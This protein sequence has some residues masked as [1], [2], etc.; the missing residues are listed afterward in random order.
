MEWLDKGAYTYEAEHPPLAP[1]A[2][3]LGPY[4][5]DSAPRFT[6]LFD[7]GNAS[8]IRLP[9]LANLTAGPSSAICHFLLLACSVIFLW[10][11]AGIP[12]AL[13]FGQSCCS[14]A[15]PCFSVT[16]LWQPRYGPVRPHW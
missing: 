1:V 13:D 7:E 12:S 8:S 15:S 3:A 10:G 9:I 2:V 6:D 16:P 14:L 5:A 11:C 4:L